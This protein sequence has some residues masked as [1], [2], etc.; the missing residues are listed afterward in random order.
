MSWPAVITWLIV[1]G[2]AGFL[3][4]MLV[5]RRRRGYGP[6]ANLGIGL[7]GALLGGGLVRAFGIDF[8]LGQIEVN[9]Q[10]LLAAFL[11]SLLFLAG[12]KIYAWLRGDDPEPDR[13]S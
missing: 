9:L 13:A 6:L 7:V 10:D 5:K 3:A 11:G 1:G 2:L 4:G 12:L 8:G